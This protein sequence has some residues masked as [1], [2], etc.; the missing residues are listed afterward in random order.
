MAQQSKEAQDDVEEKKPVQETGNIGAQETRE[1]GGKKKMMEDLKIIPAVENA[2]NLSLIESLHTSSM[3]EEKGENLHPESSAEQGRVVG[4]QEIG[5][6]ELKPVIPKD[7]GDIS[8]MENA[9]HE[10]MLK[11]LNMNPVMEDKG[12]NLQPKEGS[13]ERFEG[14]GNRSTPG[15]ILHTKK[16]ECLVVGPGAQENREDMCPEI[17][18]A[19]KQRVQQAAENEFMVLDKGTDKRCK[20]KRKKEKNEV[21]KN[22]TIKFPPLHK[23]MVLLIRQ[24]FSALA[25]VQWSCWLRLMVLL[26]NVCALSS[27]SCSFCQIHKFC[28]E[29]NLLNQHLT[30]SIAGKENYCS[31]QFTELFM[32]ETCN[33]TVVILN[34]TQKCVLL[35][36]ADL[37]HNDLY[38]EYGTGRTLPVPAALAGCCDNSSSKNLEADNPTQPGA[39]ETGHDLIAVLILASLGLIGHFVAIFVAYRCKRK[40]TKR[41][42]SKHVETQDVVIEMRRVG[43]T[44]HVPEHHHSNGKISRIRDQENLPADRDAVSMEDCP[45]QDYSEHNENTLSPVGIPLEEHPEMNLG[46]CSS[47]QGEGEIEPRDDNVTKPL[48]IP[49]MAVGK[50]NGNIVY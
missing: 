13:V 44:D 19:K 24:M 16:Q 32:K 14:A 50:R 48:L 26:L 11:S 36:M 46:T 41:G 34:E 23:I 12:V 27:S 25:S 18:P 20:R 28:T 31:F 22:S 21:K 8:G 38:L 6:D 30:I 1:D 49:N 35:Y 2:L 9:T 5:V 42:T 7:V 10:S 17:T 47:P 3:I 37:T 4:V 39:A 40:R 43:V 29:E 45:E 15:G 33:K